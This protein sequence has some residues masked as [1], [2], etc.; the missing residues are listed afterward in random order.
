[1]SLSCNSY[2]KAQSAGF[3]DLAPRR[4]CDSAQGGI[5]RRDEEC[6]MTRNRQRL[7]GCHGQ[8]RPRERME[9]YPD[10]DEMIMGALAL[11]ASL[12]RSRRKFS[13]TQ[14][15]GWPRSRRTPRGLAALDARFRSPEFMPETTFAALREAAAATPPGEAEAVVS[16]NGFAAMQEKLKSLR[17]PRRPP[18]LGN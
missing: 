9:R 4:L 6:E 17:P 14:S 16:T 8:A 3:V 5:P 13:M 12:T 15:P 10:G 18:S 2:A 1:M 7:R 11:R